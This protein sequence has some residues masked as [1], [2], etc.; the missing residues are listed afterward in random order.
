MQR[1]LAVLTTAAAVVAGAGSFFAAHAADPLPADYPAA[2]C[3]LYADPADDS[4]DPSGALLTDPTLDI[5]GFALET[6]DTSLKAY[7]RVPGLSN[8]PQDEAP[9]DGRRFTLKFTFNKHVFSAAGSE[10]AMGS[11]PIRDGLA[12]TGQAGH[13]T[14][15]GVDTPAVDPTDPNFI[16]AKGFVDSGLKVTF[17]YTNGF[18]NFDLPIADI[19]KYGGATFAGDLTGVVVQAQTDEYVVSSVWDSAPDLDAS[20]AA[21]GKW[22]VGDN[23]CFG[24]PAAVITNLGATKVQYGDTA[25]VASKVTDAS[26]APIAG[27]PITF[28]LGHVVANAKT[29]DKGIATAKLTPTD[30]AGSYPLSASFSG[31]STVGK[32][33]LSTP[34]AITAEKSLLTLAAKANG[35]K[36]IVTATLRDDD[37]HALAKQVV[38]WFVNG[39]TAG[40]ST[41]SKTGTATFA[42]KHGQT[43]K[44]VF[45]GVTGKYAGA[46]ASRKV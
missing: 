19:Q 20:N 27:A 4:A 38:A 7:V 9:V 14:Q 42:A 46:R 35:S 40:K 21:V 11:G 37:R 2:G 18:V 43:V 31:S 16:T 25:T 12:Q 41:T 3:F 45:A 23:K 33:A 6:T 32:A 28:T 8:N 24:P 29:N 15:L 30:S 10:Y 34:F 13:V 5:S 26:G 39:K 22:T 17:D 1:R 36:R 44:V